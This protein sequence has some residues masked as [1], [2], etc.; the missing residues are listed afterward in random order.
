[1]KSMKKLSVLLLAAMLCCS[2]VSCGGS[3]DSTSSES[4]SAVQSESSSYSDSSSQSDSSSGTS[5]TGESSTVSTDY[6]EEEQQAIDDYN[7]YDSTLMEYLGE[8][9]LTSR[10]QLQ[11]AS[12][13][14][15]GIKAC[16]DYF[17]IDRETLE[18][19]NGDMY[20]DEQLDALYAGTDDDIREAFQLPADYP[21]S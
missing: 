8:D 21:V 9:E 15:T 17:Q 11:Q 7:T 12:G 10:V 4:S 18:T 14:A 1:M 19:L 3:E 16:I 20:T 5:N 6:T 13:N 2:A